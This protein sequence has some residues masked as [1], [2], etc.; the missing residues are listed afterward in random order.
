MKTH[1]LTFTLASILIGT[2][3]LTPAYSE[4]ELP[5]I[6]STDEMSYVDGDTILVSGEVNAV[7]FGMPVSLQ[8]ISPNGN[9]VRI[10]QLDVDSAS[11]TFGTEI[12]T[13]GPLWSNSGT[14]LIKVLYGTASRS[15]ETTF[16]FG[17]STGSII[18]IPSESADPSGMTSTDV[19]GFSVGYSIT[20]G[21]VLSIIPDVD[22]NSLI[23]GI[24]TTSE[25][26]ITI[27][28]PRSLMDSLIGDDDDEYFVLV[29]G[30]EVDFDET[31]TSTDRT[32]TIQ[33]P[34][35]AEEIEIIG[36]F[37]IPEF[38]TIAVLILAVA[39]VSIVAVSSRSRLTIMP[40]L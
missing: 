17:G 32:L 31:K 35:G 28:I 3:I 25:G 5:I 40:K 23:I 36:T 1:L 19:E 30:E 38:G 9:L 26:E 15:A 20:G 27:T 4:T 22:A 33:F 37:V 34:D 14:Y 24:S 16:E 21:N 39:I 2:L 7:L 29:D 10:A 11:K 6:V 13:G 18:T 8:I 12:S